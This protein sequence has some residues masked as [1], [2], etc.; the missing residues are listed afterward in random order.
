M[1]K[2]QVG[3]EKTNICMYVCTHNRQ[4]THYKKDYRRKN[5][6]RKEFKIDFTR[7]YDINWHSIIGT[8]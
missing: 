4:D 1:P 8:D 6:T 2:E 5:I 7:P 3:M